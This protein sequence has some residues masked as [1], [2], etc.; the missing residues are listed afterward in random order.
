MRK[1]GIAAPARFSTAAEA[2]TL[3]QFLDNRSDIKIIKQK[4]PIVGTISGDGYLRV[5]KYQGPAIGSRGP[6]RFEMVFGIFVERG[7]TGDPCNKTN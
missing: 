3:R 2:W 1:I 5:Y 4:Q 6:N 7:L